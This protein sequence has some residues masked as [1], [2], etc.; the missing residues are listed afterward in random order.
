MF[1]GVSHTAEL[2]LLVASVEKSPHPGCMSSM[3]FLRHCTL[4]LML[5]PFYL[6]FQ[7]LLT[8]EAS[9]TGSCRFLSVQAHCRNLYRKQAYAKI[10]DTFYRVGYIGAELYVVKFLLC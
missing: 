10:M 4:S 3:I 7:T 2:K 8:L 6:P 1:N 9:E 5:H